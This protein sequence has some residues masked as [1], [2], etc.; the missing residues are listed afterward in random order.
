MKQVVQRLRDGRVE[1]VDVPPPQLSA[2]G[3]LVDVRASLLSAGTERAKVEA[4]RRSLIGKARSRPD[5]V[6]QVI[7]KARR[8]GIREA[9]A[10]VRAR[11]DEPS[12]LGYSAAGV[13]MAVGSRVRGVAPGDRVACAGGDYAV[14]AEIDHVPFN[15]C[16]RLPDALTFEQ[17]AF[18]T[19]GSIAL[20]GV[21]Q[22]EVK[23]GE[24]VAVIGLGLVG[25]LVAQLVRAAGGKVF[26][27]DL[28]DELVQLA[29]TTG[30]V[31]EGFVRRELGGN[32]LRVGA[33][34]CDAVI[35]TAATKSSDPIELAADLCRERGRVVVLGD[36]G[37]QV[38]RAPFY[39][40]ELE[41][42]LSRSYGPG[43][44]DRQYEERGLDYPIGYVRWT[45]RRNMAAFLDL[46]AAGRVSI[47]P[48]IS[49]RAPV[50]LAAE[51]YERL[52]STARSP[53]GI[54]LEYEQ[55]EIPR[56][57][58]AKRTRITPDAL[59]NAGVIGAGSFA[60]RILIPGLRRGGFN[61]A[62]VASASGL[63]ASTAADRFR[64]GRSTTAED[65][66]TDQSV[67]L[68]AIST[69]H[70]SH[71]RL[72]ANALRAGK[73]VF[74][75]KPPCLNRPELAELSDA[76]AGSEWPLIVGFNR[77]H[78]PAAQVLQGRIASRLGP[79][80]LLYRVNAG[81]L[82]PDHWLN[83]LDEG[84]GR[85][86]GEGCHFV[87]FACWA[88]GALPER[89][90]CLVSNR[91]DRHPAAAQSFS[92]TMEFADGSLATVVYDAA[93]SAAVPKEY[94]EAHVDGASIVIDD[95]RELVLYD[96]RKRRRRRR[97][98]RGKGHTEQFQHL[99]QIA[100]GH[101]APTAP[102]PLDTMAVTL[103]ALESATTGRTISPRAFV[104]GGHSEAFDSDTEAG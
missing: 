20:H 61:L 82:P 85:L 37:M 93:G 64:F 59:T 87:D 48:L 72:A 36:V 2:A 104:A 81:G 89:V 103:A 14:H 100:R 70:D 49:H 99:G 102:D 51:A 65:V 38:P 40:K 90:S 47:D 3:V 4:G 78:A 80:E 66:I 10:E 46:V 77:R 79:L 96:G 1:V 42:R 33:S 44:Y 15:L 97:G 63:S 31:D 92:V 98:V 54:V 69:R 75:E 9:A 74:V 6:Q 45:E 32:G 84:G 55:A 21:R 101:R 68:V 53:L 86:V 13:V 58:L 17:G 29:R 18:A 27:F 22:A 76:S 39:A 73:L 7:D 91:E 94:I 62:A 50:D 52:L 5:Q 26:G 71:A 23:L 25:Q 12:S 8:D 57:N 24:R 16:V 35:I 30:A 95:F 83:D 43:R 41:L 34:A 56:R 60:K 88:L 19:L 67:G 11:L 28:S